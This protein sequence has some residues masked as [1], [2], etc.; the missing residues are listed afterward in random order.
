[1]PKPRQP[2]RLLLQQRPPPNP[3]SFGKFHIDP[4]LSRPLHSGWTPIERAATRSRPSRESVARAN[5]EVN[6]DE[7]R[8]DPIPRFTWAYVLAGLLALATLGF[9][10]YR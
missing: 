4:P 8:P 10:I 1:M 2:M 7:K 5:S 9:G 6:V 3:L